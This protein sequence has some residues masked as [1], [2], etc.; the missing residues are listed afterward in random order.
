[1]K[2]FEDFRKLFH[3]YSVDAESQGLNESIVNEIANTQNVST[4]EKLISIC[5]MYSLDMLHKYH[6][7]LSQ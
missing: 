6:E 2:N 5:R 7:W 1:M 4:E 3:E